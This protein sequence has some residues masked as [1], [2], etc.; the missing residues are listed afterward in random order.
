MP[1]LTPRS[2]PKTII[3]AWV[4]AL[5]SGKYKQGRGCLKSVDSP[6]ETY[7]C[8]GVLCVL[9]KKAGVITLREYKND[10]NL[11]E[12]VVKWSGLSTNNGSFELKTRK[13]SLVTLNDDRRKSFSEI[14][15]VIESNPP[16]LLRATK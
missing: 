1:N 8:L 11:P 10:L 2:K 6:D 16:R 12:K 3:A 9:A 5:R 7:C 4:Q 15:D 13:S 14:A